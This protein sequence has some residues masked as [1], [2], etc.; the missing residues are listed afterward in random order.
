MTVNDTFLSH[1]KLETRQRIV[2]CVN[3]MEGIEDPSEF[4]ELA[5]FVALHASGYLKF[6]KN[7]IVIR[8]SANRLFELFPK[9]AKSE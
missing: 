3:A 2:A 5:K 7:A 8:N 4:M 6:D 1:Y 9:E